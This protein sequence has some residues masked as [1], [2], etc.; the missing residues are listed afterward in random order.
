MHSHY[1]GDSK[2][3]AF[4]TLDYGVGYELYCKNPN[5]VTLTLTGQ[6]PTQRLSTSL[7]AGWQL[8]PSLN[9]EP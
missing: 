9:L 4:D 7:D 2:F 3:D 5:G 6:L 1:V 8:L